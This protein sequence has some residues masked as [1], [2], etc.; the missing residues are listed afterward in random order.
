MT[1][2]SVTAAFVSCAALAQGALPP[3]Q[4]IGDIAFVTG[5][6]GDEQA[7]VFKQAMPSYPLAIEVLRTSS[8]RGEYTSGA[9]VVVTTRS[10][11]PVLSA[12]AEG[13]FMLV[14]VPPGDYQVQATLS[15]RVLTRDV[16]VGAGGSARA[17]LAFAGD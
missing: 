15:G 8:G 12:R 14:R 10:G 1:L 3:E 5:G 7:T 16:S 2:L 4:R 11:N 13:P 6:V 17:V 9:Q